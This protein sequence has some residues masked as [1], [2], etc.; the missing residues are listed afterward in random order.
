[1]FISNGTSLHPTC[2]FSCSHNY[3]SFLGRC[4]LIN[5]PIF[6]SSM[7]IWTICFISM[8]YPHAISPS[9]ISIV[10]LFYNLSNFLAL[11]LLLGVGHLIF[12]PANIH[13]SDDCLWPPF[14]LALVISRNVIS[15]YPFIAMWF[16]IFQLH[17]WI[18][19]Q[20]FIIISTIY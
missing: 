1:M 9:F 20:Y 2:T 3:N 15:I 12:H 6:I 18:L 17:A 10:L 14:V 4:C 16:I 7:L 13:F 19:L 11:K 5:V 8:P